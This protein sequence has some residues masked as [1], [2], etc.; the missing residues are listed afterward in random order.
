MVTKLITDR[1]ATDVG[2]TDK[3]HYNY[4]DL[5]RIHN[6]IDEAHALMVNVGYGAELAEW[7]EWTMYDYP[8]YAETSKWLANVLKVLKGFYNREGLKLPVEINEIDYTLANNIERS[9]ELIEVLTADITRT[10]QTYA[11]SLYSNS[12][13]YGLK[14]YLK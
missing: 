11:N 6:A 12:D 9:I 2:K 10:W 4:T 5:N 13:I 14:G 3:G 7:K 8:T 1:T